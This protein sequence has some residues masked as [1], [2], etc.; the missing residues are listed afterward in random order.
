[1]IVRSM[2]DLFWRVY[3]TYNRAGLP[4][5]F[6]SVYLGIGHVGDS[7]MRAALVM[8]AILVGFGVVTLV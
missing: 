3:W 4:I 5:A 2:V 6:V 1:M 7:R 8:V